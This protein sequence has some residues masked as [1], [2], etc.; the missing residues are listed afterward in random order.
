MDGENDALDGISAEDL[1]RIDAECQ[2]P[3]PDPPPAAVA[4]PPHLRGLNS[5]QIRA[6]T[7]PPDQP[8][9]IIA[10]AGTGKTRTLVARAWSPSRAKRRRPHRHG[11]SHAHPLRRRHSQHRDAP[12]CPALLHSRAHVHPQRG[13]GDGAA[14]GSGAGP[15]RVNRA[16]LH[17]PRTGSQPL[18]ALSR[19]AGPPCRVPALHRA[20]AAPPLHRRPPRLG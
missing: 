9:S 7:V 15:P 11:R 5:A 8:L 6:A 1:A 14:G 10:G 20:P 2:A 12:R 4:P 3:R 13:A 18:Q 16:S 19:R 17:L